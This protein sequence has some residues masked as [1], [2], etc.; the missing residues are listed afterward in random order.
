M[1]GWHRRGVDSFLCESTYS[2]GAMGPAWYIGS[3]LAWEPEA[4]VGGL[5]DEFLD[6]CFGAAAAPMRRMLTR[7]SDRF[8][9]TSHEL[10]LSFRDVRAA[11]KAAGRNE[12]QTAR[13]ADYGRYVVYLRLYFEYQH[14]QR[15]SSEKRAA[16]ERLMRFIWSVYDSSMIHAFRLSQLLARDERAR[17]NDDLAKT[18]DWQD[19][20]APGWATIYRSRDSDIRRLVDRGAAELQ[21]QDFESSRFRGRLVPVPGTSGRSAAA[22]QSPVLWLSNSLEFHVLADRAGFRFVPRIATQQ[23]VQMLVT[24]PDGKSVAAQSIATG[25]IGKR[26][27]R[28]QK[29]SFRSRGCIT[30]RL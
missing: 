24:D 4:D 8:T 30:F 22:V 3:R 12:G 15:G 19:H 14:A 28:L 10:A 16:A 17:G 6:D 26:S 5:F 21:P 20:D 23:P 7:W 27:G 11:W 29:S 9:L 18:F 2:S 25:R 1:R 13:V